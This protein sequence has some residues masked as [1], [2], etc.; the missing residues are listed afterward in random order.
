MLNLLPTQRS[1][2]SLKCGIK[3]HEV[4]FSLAKPP[5]FKL[6]PIILCIN[7]FLIIVLMC[8]QPDNFKN[9][10]KL[11]FLNYTSSINCT[12]EPCTTYQ[13]ESTDLQASLRIYQSF[14]IFAIIAYTADCRAQTNSH[15]GRITGWM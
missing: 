6:F 4:F 1:H 5:L 2:T 9:I 13:F 15:N 10:S 3:N 12:Q 7:L 14:T 11:H 8:E